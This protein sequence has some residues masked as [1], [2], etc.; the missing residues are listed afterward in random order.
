MLK[1][2]I[3]G[4]RERRD[5]EPNQALSSQGFYCIADNAIMHSQLTMKFSGCFWDDE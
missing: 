1:R 2:R 4:G 5:N 3:L